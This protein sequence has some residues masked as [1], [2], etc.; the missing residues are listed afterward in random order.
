[1][2]TWYKRFSNFAFS[3]L[4]CSPLKGIFRPIKGDPSSLPTENGPENSI[5][6]T[7]QGFLLGE[8]Q[9]IGLRV[10]HTTRFSV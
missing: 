9:Q 2:Y 3:F 1:M 8:R 4:Y 10:S 5:N 6:F 7:T